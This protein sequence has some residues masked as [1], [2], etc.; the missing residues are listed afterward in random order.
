MT[1]RYAFAADALL[2]GFAVVGVVSGRVGVPLVFET[3]DDDKTRKYIG[4]GPTLSTATVAGGDQDGPVPWYTLVGADAFIGMAQPVSSWLEL[5]G[6]L[7]GSM[8]FGEGPFAFFGSAGISGGADAH[9]LIAT[10][11]SRLRQVPNMRSTMGNR[12]A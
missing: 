7:R 12:P 1:P 11:S 4:F 6:E 3:I 9:L 8:A 5:R 10:S 2:V